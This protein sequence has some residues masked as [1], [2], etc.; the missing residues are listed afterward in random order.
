MTVR[1][2]NAIQAAKTD[3]RS[4]DLAL[5]AF[6]TIDQEAIVP[7]A[8]DLRGQTPVN[9]RGGRRSTQERDFKQKNPCVDDLDNMVPRGSLYRK[10]EMNSGDARCAD[11]RNCTG[12]ARR[13]H[14]RQN[15][16][17]FV[18]E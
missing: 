17:D 9:R 18:G 13:Q 11:E 7:I 1:D 15:E 8:Y 5:G 3:S 16:K 10:V 4:K 2:Q 12:K 6:T 14:E